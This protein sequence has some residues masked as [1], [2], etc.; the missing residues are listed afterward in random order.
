MMKEALLVLSVFFMGFFEAVPI[1]ATQLEIARRS[2]NGYLSSAFMIVVG[3][4]LS[5]AMYGVIAF[6]GV[7][8]FLHN[9]T[10]VAIF[11]IVGATASALL[12][13]WAVREGRSG[14]AAIDRSMQ[15]LKKHN[16]AFFTGF[17]LAITNPFMIAYWLIGANFL[18]KAG[19]LQGFRMSDTILFLAVGSLGIA[20]YLLVL[21]MTVYKIKKFFSKQAIR[22]ITMVFGVVLLVLAAIFSFRAITV[23]RAGHG[24]PTM[25]GTDMTPRYRDLLVVGQTTRPTNVNGT[26]ATNQGFA[27]RG[28]LHDAYVKPHGTSWNFTRANSV[29]R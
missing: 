21:A 5:D 8:P 28:S 13:I 19:I 1:G 14:H 20:S 11:W 23:L 4:V 16:L 3:S 18:R 17:S 9:N 29:L 6:W 2:L 10:V 26:P 22:R 27:V 25:F 15:L 24:A 7:A 12:G